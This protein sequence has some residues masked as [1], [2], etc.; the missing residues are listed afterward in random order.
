MIARLLRADTGGLFR[1]RDRLPESEEGAVLLDVEHIE[2]VDLDRLVGQA[3]RDER[4]RDAVRLLYLRT[5]QDL[6]A[7]HLIVWKKDKTNR[8][9][10]A[11]LRRSDRHTLTQ[12]F[13]ELT[14]LFEWVWYGEAAVDRARFQAVDERFRSFALRAGDSRV[15]MEV[16]A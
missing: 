6:A 7:Q 4:Y 1:R 11:E 2:S 12:P 10:V 14:R 5:L 16:H 3:R 9:F 8:D 15:P 13:A